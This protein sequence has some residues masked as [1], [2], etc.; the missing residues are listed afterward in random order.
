MHAGTLNSNHRICAVEPETITTPT[1]T[2]VLT[3]S[4]SKALLPVKEIVHVFRFKSQTIGFHIAVLGEFQNNH[5]N[6]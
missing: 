4:I 3:V 2:E 6:N 5:Q 1:R